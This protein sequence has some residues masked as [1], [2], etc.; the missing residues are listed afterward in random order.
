MP[1]NNG[2][3]WCTAYITSTLKFNDV[4]LHSPAVPPIRSG[5]THSGRTACTPSNAM[6]FA[7]AATGPLPAP[8]R[9]HAI[10]P[11]AILFAQLSG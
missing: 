9:K 5:I 8:I 1:E 2:A 11:Y 6:M 7:A 10:A 3:L 4:K